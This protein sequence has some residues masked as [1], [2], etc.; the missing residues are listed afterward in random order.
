MAQQPRPGYSESI[1]CL[2]FENECDPPLN[3]ILGDL[4]FVVDDNLLILDPGRP[5][6]L[7]G[8]TCAG[9]TLLDGIIETPS[10]GCLDLS[11]TGDCQYVLA[12]C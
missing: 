6:F 9:C 4:T 12:S 7:Q 5:G 10:G 11:N 3:P 8:L 1:L 2:A